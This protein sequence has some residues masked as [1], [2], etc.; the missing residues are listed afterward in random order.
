MADQLSFFA[1]QATPEAQDRL[2]DELNRLAAISKELAIEIDD[3]D[4]RLVPFWR[5]KARLEQ[6]I[7][8][9]HDQPGGVL[10]HSWGKAGE[11]KPLYE[12]LL[13]LSIEYGGVKKQRLDA[14][15]MRNGYAR[16]YA[17][18]EK[19]LDKLNKRKERKR[20]KA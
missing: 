7:R 15:A 11:R 19:E 13:Q 16:D 10:V 18:I 20:G 9:T 2:R 6:A 8:Q 4:K 5:E 17:R 14:I 1:A 3:L 12:G